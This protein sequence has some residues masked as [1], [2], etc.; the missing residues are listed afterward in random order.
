MNST[1]S[2]VTTLFYLISVD[3]YSE[4]NV[5]ITIYKQYH[6]LSP[7]LYHVFFSVHT[8]YTKFVSPTLIVLLNTNVNRSIK[9]P[10][11]NVNPTLFVIP[12]PFFWETIDL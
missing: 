12:C 2:Y 10:P 4:L 11:L 8:N 1:G 3:Y 7:K 9:S 6:F 5:A